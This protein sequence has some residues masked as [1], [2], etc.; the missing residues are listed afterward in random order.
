MYRKTQIVKGCKGYY[1]KQIYLQ[2]IG[3][4]QKEHFD[5]LMKMEKKEE[6]NKY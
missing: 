2:L 1:G 5:N 3:N 6:K 4:F